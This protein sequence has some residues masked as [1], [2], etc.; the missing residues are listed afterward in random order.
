LPG[1]I[2]RLRRCV[3]EAHAPVSAGLGY[4]VLELDRG[5]F[6]LGKVL[7]RG[8]VRGTRFAAAVP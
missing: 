4:G 1:L 2:T 6:T 5:E 3:Q 7:G 8:Q